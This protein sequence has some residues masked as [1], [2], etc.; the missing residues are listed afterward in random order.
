MRFFLHYF[1]LIFLAHT[2]NNAVSES[3]YFTDTININDSTYWAEVSPLMFLDSLAKHSGKVIVIYKLP[4][5]DWYDDKHIEGLKSQ[6]ANESP[7][8]GVIHDFA[9]LRPIYKT[10]TVGKQ[11]DHL[12]EGI[13]KKRYP[14]GLSTFD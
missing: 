10:T 13:R 2:T 8:G 14:A 3:L 9:S 11:A 1:P 7:A 4:P 12:I 6:L 5:K